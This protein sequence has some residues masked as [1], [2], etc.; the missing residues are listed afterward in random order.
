MTE[1][2]N[3]NRLINEKSPY[4]LQHAYNPVDWYPWSEEAFE[5]AKSENKPV[6]VSIGYSTCHWCHVM[7]RESFENEEVAQILNEKFVSIKVDREE[8]SDIDSIYMLVCQMM[9]GHGGWPLSVFLTPDRVPFYTGTYFPQ[10]SRYG[11]PGFKEV[12]N[13]LYQQ[14]TE[15]PDRIKD[16]GAQ[17]KQALELSREKGEQTSLTKETIDNAF[18]YYK[19]TFDPQYG[20]F[21][22]APKFPM[23]HT[24][25]FLL[26]YAKFYEN[27][28]A[29][30]M[31]T[32]TLDGLA[33]GGIYDHIGYG[34]S[35]YSVDEKFLVPHFEK[36]LYDNALFAMAY[37]DAFRMTKNARYKKTTEEII[38]YVLRDMVHPDGGFYSAE[39]ADS[40][41]EEGKFYVWTPEEVKDVLGE[42]LGTLFCQAYDITKQGNFEGK[43]IP[44][45]ITSHLESI[46][47][48]E[49]ISS[50]ELA[51]KLETARQRLFQ[52]REKRVRPF[53]D[54][55]ILTAWNGLMIASLAKAGRVFHQPSYVQS[56]EKAVSFIR[57]NLIQNGR[58]MVRYR[59]GEVK[60]K[61][62]IDEYAFLLWGYIEL[63]ESTFAPFYLE[64]AKKLA[65]NMM[66][67][68]WDDHAGG[69][70][71]SGNDDEPLLVRQK[72]SYD[73]ALPSGN[74]VAACQLLRLAKLTGDFTLEEKVQQMF[75]VFSKDIHDYP[76]G[77][78][79]MLQ[80][81]MLSQQAM[82]EVVIVM[83]DETK[84]VVDFIQHIQENFHP[85]ISLM[86]VKR[87]E[88]AK[89]SEIAP[90]I[91]DYA[92]INEKPTIYV[93]ENF[94]CNQPTNHFQTA[95]DLLFKK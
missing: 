39:D 78:A 43:N 93:C 64:E 7:E 83:D 17:V 95:M 1:N 12:L 65:D 67:L 6:F 75:Q 90:F 71:F 9:N 45:L 59:D 52:H 53:R 69:F 38:K 31:V 63:Y 44:N 72:E 94:Q 60:N 40:E 42:Q 13:Y 66:D 2:K 87:N 61:A 35:R 54:D 79:M 89:L 57:D 49:G 92:M 68:F 91:E 19:Q 48:S 80:S 34:F 85:E 4:L 23:P 47:K 26:M 20:G 15:N 16:V 70:F 14:Y 81:V 21:G 36:M 37:T 33:R 27:Q 73:G 41:G 28:E 8:R 25:V 76:N 82:K 62:F 50:A 56:A 24:L 86:A 74:S 77:H 55:K 22:E 5:K 32:K 51:E 3:P 29:L 88:Q 18:R 11:M 46:A 10:E 58:V 84:E 30:N